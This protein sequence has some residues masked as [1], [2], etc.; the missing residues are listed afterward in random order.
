VYGEYQYQ[1]NF[2]GLGL[3]VV[4]GVLGSYT[5]S[6]AQLYG[7]AEYNSSN[8]GTYLQLDKKFFDRLTVSLGGRYERNT[9][10][11]GLITN[12]E[13]KSQEAKPV[14]R[15]GLN[16]QPAEYTYLRASWGQGYRYPTIAERYIS[17]DVGDLLYFFLARFS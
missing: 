16:Y 1:R 15:A 10:N 13:T 4:A 2:E 17:T 9:I 6:E 5:A 3:N 8:V 11:T 14:F 12:D 7:N